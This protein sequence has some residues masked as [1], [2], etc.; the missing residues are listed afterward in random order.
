M[1]IIAQ[2]HRALLYTSDDEF[3][4]ERGSKISIK[5]YNQKSF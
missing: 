5:E 2:K 4:Q 1:Y 3:P